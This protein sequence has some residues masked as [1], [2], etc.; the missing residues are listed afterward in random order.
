MNGSLTSMLT[1][2]A[3]DPDTVHQ[4][5][6]YYLGERLDDLSADDMRRTLEQAWGAELDDDLRRLA[7]DPTLLE[8]SALFFLASAWDEPGEQDR[9]V[10]IVED[11]KAKLPVIE[12]GMIVLG[13]MYGLYLLRTGG[14]KRTE[15][16]TIRRPDGS[17]EETLTV[18]YA[19]PHGPAS[20]LAKTITRSLPPV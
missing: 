1:E 8:N 16:T 4:S 2:R 17:F 15:R 18:E 3:V 11:A 9:I 20:V 19:D 14:V 10:E 6:L 7:S 13:V 5:V 12:V